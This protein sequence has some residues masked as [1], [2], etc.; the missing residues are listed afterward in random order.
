MTWTHIQVAKRERWFYSGRF[1]DLD[2]GPRGDLR[3]CAKTNPAAQK[4]EICATLAAPL[5]DQCRHNSRRR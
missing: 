4:P 5:R 1:C 3:I 2:K